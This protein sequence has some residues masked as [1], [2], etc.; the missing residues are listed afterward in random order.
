VL[1]VYAVASKF[2]E[3]MRLPATAC[4][5]V[6]YPR[7]SRSARDVADA[8]ARRLLPR[9]L[10]LT[11]AATP[12]MALGAVVVLPLLYGE[13]FAGAVLP[14]CVLLVGLT[15]EGAAAVASA[16]LWGI[17]RPGANSAAMAAGVLVTV[18]LDVLLIPRH[19]AMG[20]AIASSSA[21]L[22]TTAVLVVLTDRLS[23]QVSAAAGAPSGLQE[24]T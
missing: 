21:Y 24:S 14:T 19:G 10:V 1:G 11:A 4:N 7:F 12:L 6:L 22:V 5:Y 20:A 9:A 15:V 8:E 18:V 13:A 16:Y 3:L 2:A 17:G 23:R